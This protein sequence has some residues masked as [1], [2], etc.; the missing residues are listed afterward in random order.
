MCGTATDKSGFPM[1]LRYVILSLV[2]SDPQSGYDIVKSFDKSVGQI[3]QASHQQVYRELGKLASDGC[4]S[5]EREAQTDKPDRKVYSITSAGKQKLEAWI[6]SPVETPAYRSPILV[7]L[8]AL[9]VV[10]AASLIPAVKEARVAY[11]EKLKTY[12]AIEQLYGNRQATADEGLELS[13][14]M[15]LRM[16]IAITEPMLVWC[17]ET[18]LALEKIQTQSSQPATTK[19]SPL[20]ETD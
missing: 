6:A 16:A 11:D 12:Y 20:L 7:R 3:W 1:A 4:L 5:F 15:A 14:H 9:P 8:L 13:L 2:A 17:D 18:I 10:G 19:H